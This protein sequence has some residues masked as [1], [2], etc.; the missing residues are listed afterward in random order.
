MPDGRGPG[1]Y[2]PILSEVNERDTPALLQLTDQLAQRPALSLEIARFVDGCGFGLPGLPYSDGLAPLGFDVDARGAKAFTGILRKHPAF[3]EGRRLGF[4]LAIVGEPNTDASAA[5]VRRDAAELLVAGAL[6]FGVLGL[7]EDLLDSLVNVAFGPEAF[8]SVLRTNLLGRPPLD[9]EVWPAVPD[10][11]TDFGPTGPP[12]DCVLGI[13]HALTGLMLAVRGGHSDSYATGI[14]SLN[15]NVGCED[16]TTAIKGT[17]FGTTQPA[18]VSVLFPHSSG[19][20]VRATVVNWSDTEIFVKVPKGVRSGCI[21]FLRQVAAPDGGLL[22]EAAA[23]LAGELEGCLGQAASNAAQRL[24]QA[25]PVGIVRCPPCLPGG[26]NR[27]SGGGPAIDQFA[28]NG[29]TSV[30]VEPGD[31]I[32]LSWRTTVATSVTLSPATPTA[33]WI[34][35]S[36]PLP[37][38]GMHPAGYMAGSQPR[39]VKYQLVA[40][41][42]CDTMSR[43]V[44][45]HLRKTPK[46]TVT[47]IEVVQAIQRPDN[48]VRLVAGKRTVVR[49][50]VASGLT[51]GFD[52]GPGPDIQPGVGGR[53]IAFPESAGHGFDAGEPLPPGSLAAQPAAAIARGTRTHSLNFELP[54]AAC[55]GKVRLD[56]RVAVKDHELDIGGPF[57]AIGT[58]TVTFQDPPTQVVEPYLI[59]DVVNGVPAP[60]MAQYNASL[61]EARK[62]FPIAETGFSVGPSTPFSTGS[63]R[64]LVTEVGWSS[65]L[66]A[67][68]T[69]AFVHTGAIRTGLVPLDPGNLRGPYALNGM[70]FPRFGVTMPALLSQ[71]GL[72]GTFA[73]E[74]GHTL[75]INHAPN[76]TTF[77]DNIDGRLPGN[78]EE[79]GFDVPANTLIPAGRGE[80]MSYRGD[81]SRCP[82][83]TRWPSIALWDLLFDSLGI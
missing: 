19:T 80:L 77:W 64:D 62:R 54:L 73:H 66:N 75:S 60:S 20:C 34:P 29:G 61:Q 43:S 68:A 2:G 81:T 65:L 42:A 41:N 70:G 51:G 21:G 40:R 82:G 22:A 39:T 16:Q 76:C 24:R 45:V 28:A 55:T 58:T 10:W 15:P 37:V 7:S 74:M 49:V 14:T 12:Y 32:I 83:P 27:F 23:T 50:F 25:G 67:L 5:G 78:T 69:L 26:A 48:S 52:Y 53:V 63:A 36:G 17:G 71:A 11:L 33:P 79:V 46:L 13:L 18:D 3:A 57:V 47:A 44:E 59:V 38:N 8:S 31:L 1:E 35:P 56:V 4:G 6:A 30:F 72:R 9:Q